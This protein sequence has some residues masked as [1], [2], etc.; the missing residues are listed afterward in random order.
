MLHETID[1][2]AGKL[3]LLLSHQNPDSCFFLVQK[4]HFVV[5]SLNVHSIFLELAFRTSKC[6]I[7]TTF[8]VGRDE[9]FGRKKEGREKLNSQKSRIP[10]AF[11]PEKCVPPA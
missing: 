5:L 8:Y 9:T 7:W 2:V 4:R 11:C 1:F 3:V 6:R 10:F